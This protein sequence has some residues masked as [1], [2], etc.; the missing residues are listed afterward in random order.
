MFDLRIRLV[1]DTP[2]DADTFRRF[3]ARPYAEGIVLLLAV[4]IPDAVRCVPFDEIV[5]LGWDVDEAWRSAALQTELL[6]RPEELHTISVD[7]A[8]FFHVFGERPFTASMTGVIDELI[9]S[10]P[11]D[12][13]DLRIDFAVGTS[14]VV[15]PE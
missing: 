4:D 9:A 15:T 3:G 12:Q 5:A 1:P 6:E 13:Y 8:E 10:V 11:L 14:E 7:G 2:A